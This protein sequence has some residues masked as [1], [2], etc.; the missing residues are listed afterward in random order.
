MNIQAEDKLREVFNKGYK[1]TFRNG[2]LKGSKAMCRVIF[3][4]ANNESKTPEDRI[5]D[6]KNF[7]KVSLGERNPEVN[8]STE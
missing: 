3:D 5:E 2:L 7:C 6:I 4:K 8:S 1:N